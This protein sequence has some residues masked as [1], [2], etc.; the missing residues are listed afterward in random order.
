MIK[1]VKTHIHSESLH[2]WEWIILISVVVL[3]S[4]LYLY[5]DITVTSAKGITLWSCLFEGKL[6]SFG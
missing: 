4:S 5:S 3:L 1:T 6:N 2:L